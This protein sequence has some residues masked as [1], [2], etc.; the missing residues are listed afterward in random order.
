VVAFFGDLPFY[1][2]VIV[3]SNIRVGY[4]FLA[5]MMQ[6]CRLIVFNK[7]VKNI[8]MKMKNCAY[9][10]KFVHLFISCDQYAWKYIK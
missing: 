2:E 7:V 9:T 8:A 5:Y 1:F 3:P 4:C 10:E 6:I